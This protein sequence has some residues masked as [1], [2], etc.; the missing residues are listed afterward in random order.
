MPYLSAYS[1][2]NALII[3]PDETITGAFREPSYNSVIARLQQLNPEDLAQQTSIIRGSLYA[4]VATDL[5]SAILFEHQRPEFDRFTPLSP[6]AML[7]Q[8][9]AI[10]AISRKRQ[11]TR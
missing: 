6:E 7:Q 5:E 10:G 8:A 2:G 3:S 1:D 4:L 11:F 9:L